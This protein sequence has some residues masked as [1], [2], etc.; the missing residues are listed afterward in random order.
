MSQLL[1]LTLVDFLDALS[2]PDPTP[3]GGSAAA[4]AG[5]LGA[6]LLMMVAGLSKSRTNT[7]EEHIALDEARAAL[8]ALR[9]RLAGLAEADTDA[10]DQVMAAYRLPKATDDEK[11]SRKDAIQ[12]A[13]KTATTVPL[14]TLRTAADAMALA[15]PVA[16]HG[17]R[18]ATSDVGVGVSL[19]DAA[20]S[21]AAANVRINLEGIQDA[22]FAAAAQ[23]DLK[24]LTERMA[25]DAAAARGQLGG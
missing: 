17:I 13:L 6:S 20:A 15:R 10:Y 3:G 7:A 23:E 25:R 19:L 16:E 14:D 22:A 5:A 21:G 8:T 24:T 2:R 4:I 1:N 11:A 9:D 18:S 12:L